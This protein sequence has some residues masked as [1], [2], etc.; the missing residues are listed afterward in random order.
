MKGIPDFT[1]SG[2][3]RDGATSCPNHSTRVPGSPQPGRAKT[4]KQQTNWALLATSK[5]LDIYEEFYR[6][7]LCASLSRDVEMSPSCK[8]PENY[9]LSILERALNPAISWITTLSSLNKLSKVRYPLTFPAELPIKLPH[10]NLKCSCHNRGVVYRPR[11]QFSHRPALYCQLRELDQNAVVSA[12]C[13][14]NH[15]GV[16][17][18][19]PHLQPLQSFSI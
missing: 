12:Y 14:N 5:H 18:P 6:C 19:S 13:R 3:L 8:M 7:S 9:D 10:T 2:A 1:P 11:A 15:S 17:F 4:E 16:W